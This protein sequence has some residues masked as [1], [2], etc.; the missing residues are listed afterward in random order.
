MNKKIGLKDNYTL[1]LLGLLLFVLILFTAAKPSTFWNLSIWK[2]M[3]MQF[4]EYGVMT[5]GVMLCFIGG[6]I[7]VSFIALGDFAAIIACLYMIQGDG[8]KGVGTIV[9]AI[10]IAAVVGALGGLLNGNL[11]TRVGIPPIL[12][13]LATQLV[14]RGLSIALTRGDAV[15][16]LPMLYSE[17]GHKNLF[18]FL[19]VPLCVFL[20]IFGLFAFLLRKTAYGKKLYMVGANPKAAKFSAINTTRMINTTF[21]I[22]GVCAS[23]GAML[24]VSTMNSAKADYGSSYLMLCILILVLAGVLPDG[25]F[26]KIKNVLIAIVTTQIISSGVNMFPQLNSYYRNLIWG[27]MLLVVLMAT[28]RLLEDKKSQFDLLRLFTFKKVNK[29]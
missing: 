7:D 24:M 11:I 1:I 21:V 9:I 29:S 18:G 26:G 25:G 6:C 10:L 15:T 3:T 22:N 5:L 28:T 16:G 2:S 19:P 27:T 23:I 8:E 12:A 17:L 13:T 20:V 4:P 14:F